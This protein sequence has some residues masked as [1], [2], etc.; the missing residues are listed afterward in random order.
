MQTFVSGVSKALEWARTTPRA[1]VIE[2]SRTIIAKRQR[3]EDAS[4]LKYWRGFGVEANGGVMRRRDFQLWIDWM[5]RA[6]GLRSGQMEPDCVY[7]NR[8]NPFASGE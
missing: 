2:R 1:Q 6:G 7:T 3:N 5:A 4:L 8:F